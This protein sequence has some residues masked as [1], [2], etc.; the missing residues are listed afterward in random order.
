MYSIRLGSYPIQVQIDG[1]EERK[2]WEKGMNSHPT[3]TQRRNRTPRRKLA[4]YEAIQTQERKKKIEVKTKCK[5]KWI[6]DLKN[7]RLDRGQIPNGGTTQTQERK[8]K[9]EVKTK[10]KPKWIED[11]E[12]RSRS[13]GRTTSTQNQRAE[14]RNWKGREIEKEEKSRKRIRKKKRV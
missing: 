5:P 6:E 13:N 3:Y 8:K 11:L 2:V 7:N 9:I 1:Q 10:F 14:G 12:K 4:H